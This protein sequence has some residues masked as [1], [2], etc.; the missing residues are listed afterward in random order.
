MRHLRFIWSGLLL[1]TILATSTGVAVVSAPQTNAEQTVY[2][3]RRG[4]TY[5]RLGCRYL[6]R[7]RIP[8]KLK[9]A[10]IAGYTPCP[11]CHPPTIRKT[12]KTARAG[13]T[14][15]FNR[16]PRRE[17]SESFSPV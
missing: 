4:R 5:H 9:D 7:S 16:K 12:S 2:V 14:R 11:V 10:V 8:V 1:A 3:N 15:S 13:K 17:R 6:R